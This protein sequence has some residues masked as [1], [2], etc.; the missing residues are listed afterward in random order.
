MLSPGLHLSNYVQVWVAQ[1]C[2]RQEGPDW[3]GS[4]APGDV[5]PL[6]AV[7]LKALQGLG[8]L[9]TR[10]TSGRKSGSGWGQRHLQLSNTRG[11]PAAA[12]RNC[13]SDLL[14]QGLAPSQSEL[15]LLS[16]LILNSDG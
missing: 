6:S 8:F 15:G 4:R 10:D 1:P 7:T 2:A 16:V 12:P 14:P 13:S 3:G 9:G 11:S 5:L